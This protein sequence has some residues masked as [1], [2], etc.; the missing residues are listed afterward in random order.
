MSFEPT[1]IRAIDRADAATVSALGDL[2]VATVHEAY[3]RRG[4]MHG[5]SAVV[6][7][8]PV[9]GTAV[10]CLN[11]PGDNL[12]LHAAI[13]VCQPGDVL[14]AAVTA[15]SVHGMLGE[16]IATICQ[17]RGV[18]GVILDS[19]ARDVNE[20]RAMGYPVYARGITALG[21][22]KAGLGY[23]NTPVS[24]GGIVVFPGDAVIADNDGVVVVQREDVDQ[25]LAAA[26]KR[27]DHEK[28]VSPRYATGVLS[29]DT[30]TMRDTLSKGNVRYV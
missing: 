5:I 29:L 27:A 6:P 13:E 17:A 4:L 26:R 2:G 24:C 30:G 11:Y 1:V 16:L 14:I 19:G 20:L 21:T 15:P 12:M 10:T 18:A 25:T 23:V 3:R 8:A 22:A 9:S 7:D 28:E